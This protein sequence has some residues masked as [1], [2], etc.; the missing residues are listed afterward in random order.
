MKKGRDI[1]NL[2]VITLEN[3]RRLGYVSELR[4][5][6]KQAEGLYV[7]GEGKGNYYIPL[8][9]VRNLGRDAVMVDGP[10]LKI[11]KPVDL[12]KPER[13]LIGSWVMTAAGENLGT[14]EDV[15]FEENDGRIVGYEVSD[16]LLKDMLMG[17]KVLSA[18]NVLSF[19]HDALIVNNMD[20]NPLE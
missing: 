1:V 13:M 5:S 10:L 12:D 16:G 6:G 9:S 11:E 15:V 18:S 14:I 20:N 3:G 7:K 2:P 17:R 4:Y 19:G 8:A